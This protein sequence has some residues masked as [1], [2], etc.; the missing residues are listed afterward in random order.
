MQKLWIVILIGLGFWIVGCTN[1]SGSVAHEGANSCQKITEL[2]KEWEVEQKIAY[3][4]KH[5]QN[6]SFKDIAVDKYGNS[7]IS[8]G[9]K[10]TK[11]NCHQKKVWQVDLWGKAKSSYVAVKAL[12][13]DDRFVYVV[14]GYFGHASIVKYDFQG[15]RFFIGKY[16]FPESSNIENIAIDKRGNI[17]VVAAPSSGS[18]D[19]V[20]AKYNSKGKKLWFEKYADTYFYSVVIDTNGDLIVVG[21]TT[22]DKASLMMKY[23]SKG[24]VL[25]KKM[26]KN[27]HEKDV[28]TFFS[29]DIDNKNN[30]Y[31][32]GQTSGYVSYLLKF[33]SSGKKLWTKST[34]VTG[35]GITS[36]S[37]VLCGTEGKIYLAGQPRYSYTSSQKGYHYRLLVAAYDARGKLLSKRV[38]SNQK[39][40][41]KNDTLFSK[42]SFY[43]QYQR[44]DGTF[45]I[46][47]DGKKIYDNLKYV[48]IL[49]EE[50]DGHKLQILDNQ[51]RVHIVFI[52]ADEVQVVMPPGFI[53][54]SGRLTNKADIIKHKHFIEVE[55]SIDDIDEYIVKE[56][57]DVNKTH[58][59]LKVSKNKVDELFFT[60]YKKQMI[61]ESGD[62]KL[63]CTLFYKKA[64]KYGFFGSL[65][66][67][68]KFVKNRKNRIV[69]RFKK[70][71]N[72]KRYD[73]LEFKDKNRILLG[74]NGLLGYYK[75]ILIKYKKLDDFKEGL[76]RFELPDG[77]KGYVDLKGNEY[78]D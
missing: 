36:G 25:W 2:Q 9:R 46:L 63:D 15:N 8:R 1:P 35:Y 24:N 20:I 37:V 39:N 50:R 62:S 6:E 30:L 5:T 70:Y 34:H 16:I 29:V 4:N 22:K 74:K 26:F 57:T 52:K 48:R 56:Y 13:V 71:K 10:L 49:L 32:S 65:S 60:K 75:L 54:D 53:C 31:V 66:V 73:I 76:A 17:F 14:F 19:G 67:D 23:D 40:L 51:N 21:D 33:T 45:Y 78:Y 43:Q 47:Q 18:G 38:S 11:Y 77:R 68:Y 58:S 41:R 59:V 55:A 64:N 72:H 27:I 42:Y 69:Y 3:I 12:S 7:Y 44:K 61:F 28:V